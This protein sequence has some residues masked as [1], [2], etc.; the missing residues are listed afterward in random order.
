MF[1]ANKA[2]LHTQRRRGRQKKKKQ[3]VK[4][5]EAILISKYVCEVILVKSNIHENER[6]NEYVHPAPLHVTRTQ[7]QM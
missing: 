3:K 7:M 2:S 4:H 1:G 6:G 5:V